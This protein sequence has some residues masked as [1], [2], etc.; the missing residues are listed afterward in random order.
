MASISS[1]LE[2]QGAHRLNPWTL[3][4]LM[5]GVIIVTLDISLT[6]TAV[7]AISQGLGADPADTIW[8]INIYYL[9]VIAMLLPLG[10]LGEIYGHRRVFLSGLLV[11]AAGSMASAMADT[12][13][14]LMAGRGLLGLGAAAVSATTPALIRELYPPGKLGRGLGLYAVIVGVAFTAGPT[15][16]SIILS[17]APWHWLFIPAAPW[18]LVAAVLGYKGLPAT[19]RNIRPFDPVA[20]IVCAGMFA[21]LLLGVSG[22]AHLG[23]P[24]VVASFA[25]TLV[26]AYWLRRREA[27]QAAPVFAV[28]LFGIRFFSLSVVTAVSAFAV[29]GLAFVVLPFLFITKL[30]YSQVEAGFLLTPWPATLVLMTV[31]VSRI[32]EH[33][34]PAVLGA[35]GLAVVAMGLWL[36]VSVPESVSVYD[37]AW[38]LALCGLGYG[39]FQAP[40]MVALMDSAPRNRSGSAGGILATA[41]LLGQAIGATIV[42]LCLSVW[43]DQGIVVALWLGVFLA[44]L[45]CIVSAVRM[46]RF[47]KPRPA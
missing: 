37:L 17:V 42:A 27:G 25:V 38:R 41:R 21:A 47:A 3:F 30:G 20:A 16:A 24:W 45:G 40:N 43:S 18:A 11:F 9:A 46:T 4:A 10:A 19:P 44:A 31:V 13:T 7:P 33:I 39:L 29:Q 8:I 6:S 26:A 1:E 35:V 5:L 22:I 32:V 28:D 34:T 36:L 12:L 15:V 2:T 14:A 23:W